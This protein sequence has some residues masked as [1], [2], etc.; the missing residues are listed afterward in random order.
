MKVANAVA[1]GA[2]IRDGDGSVIE[3]PTIRPAWRAEL[4]SCSIDRLPG[5]RCVVHRRA[6]LCVVDDGFL[7]GHLRRF[8]I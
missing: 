7:N 8:R 4:R 5:G 6:R 3:L 2:A 1:V